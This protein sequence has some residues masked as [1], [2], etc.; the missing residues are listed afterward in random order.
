MQINGLPPFVPV[1]E[2]TVKSEQPGFDPTRE[3]LKSALQG[4]VTGGFSANGPDPRDV[5]AAGKS[6]SS[7]ER[8]KDNKEKKDKQKDKEYGGD[9]VELSS[10][11]RGGGRR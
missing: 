7:R 5:K 2:P 3:A 4:N 11:A 9:F 10:L 1:F 6:E 8:S